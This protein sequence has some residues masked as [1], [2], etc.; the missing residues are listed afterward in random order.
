MPAMSYV[1]LIALN[2][3]RKDAGTFVEKDGHEYAVFV[4]DEGKTARVIDNSCPHASGNLAGGDVEK[5]V[6]TCP[7]HQWQFDLSSGVCTHSDQ[8]RVR[9]YPATIRDGVVWIDLPA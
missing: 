3:C 2:R 7:W 1:E 8:A 6:V 9:P 5:N 4:M